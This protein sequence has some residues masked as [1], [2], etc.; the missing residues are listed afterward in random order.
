MSLSKDILSDLKSF[1]NKEKAVFFPRF[2]KTGKGEYGEG[3][4]FW[5]ITV[6]NIRFVAKKYFKKISFDELEP[7][8]V[9]PVHEVRLCSYIILTYKFEKADIEGKKEVYIFYIENL[10]GC[11]N[12]DIV[13]LSCYKILGEY[14][15]ITNTEK[16]ILYQF[17]DS[18]DLWKQRISIVSTYAFLRRNEY[19]DTLKISRILL[20]HK[21]DLIHK[22]VGWMLRELGKRD[23]N[24]LREFLNENIKSMPRTTLRYSIEKMSEAEK[25]RYLSM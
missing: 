23:I 13:D 14:L 7:L 17:A 4:E 16:G 8:L 1:S 21:H 5:G 10:K 20:N 25:K 15:Y 6:P 9:H 3:D 19:E 24:V 11:N 18:N 2:F 22:A 12:W